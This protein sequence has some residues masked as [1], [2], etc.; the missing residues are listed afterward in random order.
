M[1]VSLSSLGPRL[2]RLPDAVL[3]ALALVAIAAIAVFKIYAAQD[4]PV[5]D[6]FLIPVA[7][8]GWL[9]RSRRCG[10]VAAAFAATATVV[11]AVAGTAT[12][13]LGAVVAAATLRLILYVI[14]LG[15]IDVMR[16]TL[17][18]RHSEART[19]PQTGAANARAFRDAAEAEIER[20]RRYGHPLS[21]LYM[22]V[23]DFKTVNDSFGHATGDHV[24]RAVSHA[25]RQS[26]RRT[27]TVAR[28]GGDEFV[29]LM[30]E[31]DRFAAS[32]VANRVQE[33]LARVATPD[34]ERIHCSFGVATMLEAPASVDQLL[35]AA[36]RLMY[37]AKRDGAD[38][39]ESATV[40]TPAPLAAV[41]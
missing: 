6:F 12:A 29:I 27:D 10:Y 37:R 18:E 11:I 20:S 1:R 25:M 24:L 34:G 36:D 17:A 9:S 13:P 26:V 23:D 40:A 32:T 33:E 14:T 8:V 35:Q 7:A 31:T 16:R 5:A 4:V 3:L 38:R 28:L 21:L 30:P 2:R 39:I 41:R 15:F 22:D 19:D